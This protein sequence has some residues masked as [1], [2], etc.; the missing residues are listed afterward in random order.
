MAAKTDKLFPVYAT[1]P[2]APK[3]AELPSVPVNVKVFEA[4]KVL[5]SA[6][7]KVD[8][9]AGAVRVTL[10]TVV[11]VAT[12]MFGV[13]SV[14]LV[15][16]TRRPEPVSSEH[17]VANCAEVPVK[18]LLPRAKV[19]F[20]SVS[21]DE[22]VIS[23]PEVGRVTFVEPVVVSVKALAPDVAKF[24]ARVK[25]PVVTVI[26]VAPELI[27]TAFEPFPAMSGSFPNP[28][29]IRLN[30]DRMVELDREELADGAPVEL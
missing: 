16:K 13:V 9:D 27:M 7:V 12:P 1:V 19:L 14:G 28:S 24:P 2:P 22:L 30:S 11:A 21:E 4:V 15:A 29:S 6:I 20:V 18:V 25:V 23:V 17:A 10:F 5:P 3:A 8:P 26:A